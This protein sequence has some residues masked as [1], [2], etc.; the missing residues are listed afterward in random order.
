VVKLVEGAD[1]DLQA[2]ATVYTAL[3]GELEQCDQVVASARQRIARAGKRLAAGDKAELQRLDG[4]ARSAR[5]KLIAVAGSLNTWR[6]R[7]VR[8]GIVAASV[9]TF[10]VAGV[11]WV[12]VLS[13][14]GA[15]PALGSLGTVLPWN[16]V[17]AVLGSWHCC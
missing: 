9:A 5:A 12:G 3:A 2:A 8:W 17:Q 4:I 7:I 11:V 6:G 15:L 16:L 14:L 1:A 10:A 13:G